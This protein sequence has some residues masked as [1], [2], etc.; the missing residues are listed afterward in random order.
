M[1]VHHAAD[2]RLRPAAGALARASPIRIGPHR[3]ITIR[4]NCGWHSSRSCWPCSGVEAIA[5]LTGVMKRPVPAD[6]Q[7]GDLGRRRGSRDLQRRARPSACSRSSRLDR[8]KHHSRH[9]R[10]PHRHLRRPVGR[11]GGAH[12]RRS[13]LLLSATNTAITDMISIQYLMARDGELPQV[14]GRAQ[15]LR[16]ALDARRLSRRPCRSSCCSSATIWTASPPS[17]RSA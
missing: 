3:R 14:T 10:V 17:M 12:R 15:S 13:L 2:L 4:A 1:V 5:N 8:D 11:M 16:R 9:A 6:R 7:Q